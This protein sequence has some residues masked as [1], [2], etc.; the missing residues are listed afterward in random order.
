MIIDDW[1]EAIRN[2]Q[3]GDSLTV[4]GWLAVGTDDTAVVGSDSALGTEVFRKAH[5][6]KTKI[7]GDTIRYESKIL[8]TE[9]NGNVLREYCEVNAASGGTIMNREVFASI[10]KSD[11]F[12]LR[13]QT[14]CEFIDQ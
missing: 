10:T 11:A 14:D 5:D 7:N 1:I 4:P 3:Y 9:A 8:T 6:S 13:I 2:A 12:E